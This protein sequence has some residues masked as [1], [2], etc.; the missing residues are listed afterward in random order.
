MKSFW[1]VAHGH[2]SQWEALCL[3]L[4]IAVHGPSLPYVKKALEEAVSSYIK[5]AL[6]EGEQARN[7]LLHRRAPLSV[8]LPWAMRLF[9]RSV[10]SNKKPG[11]DQ[12]A[13]FPISCPA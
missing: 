8:R 4:D 9:F 7:Q 11:N 1:C 2:G 3:D 6:K 5:D 13:G 10:F 12:V